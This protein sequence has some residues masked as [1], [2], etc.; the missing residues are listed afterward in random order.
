MPLPMEIFDDPVQSGK[1]YQFHVSPTT[2][3]SPSSGRSF[4]DDSTR[5]QAV[6]ARDA[7]ADGAFVYAVRSTKI[8]CRPICKARL[9]RQA[10]VTYYTTGQLAQHAGYR[11][12]KRCKPDLAGLMPEDEA[13]RK[14]WA[15]LNAG[16]FA[17]STD[18]DPRASLGQMAKQAG[19]SKWHFHRVFKRCIGVTP[20]EYLNLQ[21]INTAAAS[22]SSSYNTDAD[23]PTDF[24]MAALIGSSNSNDM[25]VSTTKGPLK[26]LHGGEILNM[27]EFLSWPSHDSSFDGVSAG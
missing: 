9:P 4:Q 12:C 20:I 16:S 10:N 5:W 17:T 23:S 18:Q 25:P 14:I 13:V 19:L 11:A 8:Y 26:Q 1:D 24:V 2:I 7:S 3:T 21:R 22:G 15:F 6:K 27:D